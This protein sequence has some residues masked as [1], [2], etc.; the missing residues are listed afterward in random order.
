M[1]QGI[2]SE[3]STSKSNK[4]E[5]GESDSQQSPES[6][7]ADAVKDLSMSS[8]SSDQKN[9]DLSSISTDEDIIGFASN[10]SDS[11]T[12]FVTAQEI[13]NEQIVILKIKSS[14]KY[15]SLF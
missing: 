4:P 10:V 6:L 12:H 14:S 7:I 5:K 1:P 3:L 9:S 15:S 8:Q 11:D 13:G 2:V